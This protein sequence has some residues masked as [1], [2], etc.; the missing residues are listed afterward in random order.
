MTRFERLARHYI[1][2]LDLRAVYVA[3]SAAA[4]VMV[5]LTRDPAGKAKALRRDRAKMLAVGWFPTTF[6][7]VS[8]AGGLR[9]I[10][11]KLRTSADARLSM[12]AT[13][14]ALG[15]T[16]AE[17]S[18]VQARVAAVVEDIN[19]RVEAMQASG[20]LRGLNADYRAARAEASRRGV[21]IMSY[22]EYLAR[23]KIR[24]AYEI[25]RAIRG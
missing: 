13:A 9:P 4:G 1:H 5:G 12:A 14:L 2:A 3:S 15:T 16:L 6:E 20:H 24:M 22:G 10:A 19:R 25:G 21:P 8:V 7:A 11:H 23:Y 17:D 18:D